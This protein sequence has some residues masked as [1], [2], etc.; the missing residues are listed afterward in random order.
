M[1]NRGGINHFKK[2]LERARTKHI[3]VDEKEQANGSCVV[4]V[5]KQYLVQHIDRTNSTYNSKEMFKQAP[6]SEAT[7]AAVRR[8]VKPSL[9]S[10]A[11][12]LL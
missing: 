12:L 4:H 2:A 5:K 9:G 10:L 11:T 7:A 8:A 1:V 6:F 3:I